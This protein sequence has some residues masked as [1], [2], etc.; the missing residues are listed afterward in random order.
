VQSLIANLVDNAIRH[1]LPGGTAEISTALTDQGA[2]ITV[3][4]SGSLVPPDAVDL[5]FQPFR[6]FDR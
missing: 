1:N 3:S 4:N 5:L 6:Q 2:V